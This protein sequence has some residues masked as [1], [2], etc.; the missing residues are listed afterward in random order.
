[1]YRKPVVDPAVDFALARVVTE[2]NLGD[3]AIKRRNSFHPILYSHLSFF[4]S[5]AIS[6]ARHPTDR[7]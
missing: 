3:N 5:I 2:V 6:K 4:F 1:L 7:R